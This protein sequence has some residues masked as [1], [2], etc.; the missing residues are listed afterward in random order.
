MSIIVI[1]D[2]DY[3]LDILKRILIKNGFVSVKCY[4]KAE[5]VLESLYNEPIDNIDLFLV[6]RN[7]PGLSGIEFTQIIR[8]NPKTCKLPVVMQTASSNLREVQEG[9]ES[10]V[11]YY[12]TKPFSSKDLIKTVNQALE[13]KKHKTSLPE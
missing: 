11:D 8:S 5:D 12:V 2:E 6:D 1:D 10:G 13:K 3:N 4:N 9:I 7:L